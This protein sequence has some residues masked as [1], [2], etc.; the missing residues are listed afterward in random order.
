MSVKLKTDLVIFFIQD[1]YILI[2][3]TQDYY[4]QE[5]VVVMFCMSLQA[6]LY[7]W[8]TFCFSLSFIKLVF[9]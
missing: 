7:L 5:K 2:G 9:L 4:S 6:K 8:I 3:L 1:I